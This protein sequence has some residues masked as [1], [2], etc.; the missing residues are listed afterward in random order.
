MNSTV[1]KFLEML[2]PEM[3]VAI[4][5][6]ILLGFLLGNI[7]TIYVIQRRQIRI[8]NFEI[9]FSLGLILFF[10]TWVFIPSQLNYV[11]I[12][13]TFVVA[14]LT[15]RS[16]EEMKLSRIQ[17]NRPVMVLDFHVPFGSSIIMLILTNEGRS[18]AKDITIS[19]EPEL[20]T[21]RGR[22]ISQ[23]RLFSKPIET[24]VAGKEIK[25]VFDG[26]IQYLGEGK[27][28]PLEFE[29]RICYKDME[30]NEYEEKM[31]LDLSMYKNIHYIRERPYKNLEEEVVRLRRVI[32]RGIIVQ[33]KNEHNEEMKKIDE[34]FTKKFNEKNLK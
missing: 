19:I 24:F 9:I 16:I 22:N 13:A 7:I 5:V 2:T 4:I 30:N 27:N 29:V 33:S 20:I 15:F 23:S 25:Q 6:I 8:G 31:I 11:N 10:L 3:A 14:L 18:L 34:E 1:V 12:L 21:S 28:H 26:S 17:E 32:E